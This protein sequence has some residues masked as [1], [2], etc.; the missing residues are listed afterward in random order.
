[1]KKTL[2]VFVMMALVSGLFAQTNLLDTLNGDFEKGTI[3]HWRALEVRG[4]A[5]YMFEEGSE[6]LGGAVI[7]DDSN[8]GEYAAEVTFAIDAEMN[9]IVFDQMVPV[10]GEK[11]YIYKV[12]SMALS[13]EGRLRP[14][15]TVFDADAA[16]IGDFALDA[17]EWVLADYYNEYV[18]EIPTLPAGAAQINIGFR[19]M[20]ATEG[21]WPDTDVTFLIDDV[22]LY[23]KPPQVNVLDTLNGDFEKGTI[24]FWRA[25]E[26]RGGA[27]YMFEE[28]S[29]ALGGAVITDD[30]NSGEYAAEVTFAVDA[31][32]N[33][34][35][36][37]Q[38]VP[39]KGEVDYTYKVF[40]MS[41]SGEAR[42]RPHC[43]VFDADNAII[44][45][46]ALDAAEWV[47]ADYYQEYVWK[48]PTLP[49]GASLINIGFR[50]MNATEGRWPD[51]DV[52]F[53]IDDVRLE[54][55]S[56]GTPTAINE[57]VSINESSTFKCY[58]NPF[59]SSTTFSYSLDTNTDVKLSIYNINGRLTNV[60]VNQAQSRGEHSIV[61]DG[62]SSTGLSLP[63]GI[64]LG[65]LDLRD[66]ES[67][68]FKLIL[69]R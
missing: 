16:I 54:T 67:R 24:E 62:T 27:I 10:E 41:L 17:A 34:I 52:T 21:R 23:E 39:V 59:N 6:A 61:W 1:M 69:N 28:G 47:L 14:H 19:L 31:E 65:R 43:T 37:D 45:D 2:L 15:C 58:P 12:F 11:N 49:A 56:V 26:V 36:F 7:T 33:D 35:V 22:I 18:W 9:D 4:G 13:G 32:M 66:G 25:L 46:F 20:N 50:L 3:E 57:F 29:E 53:L 42:L 55:D 8:S 44:G 63:N 51:S 40:S 48:V 30:S 38:Y 68:N 5:V 60:L 64:Y